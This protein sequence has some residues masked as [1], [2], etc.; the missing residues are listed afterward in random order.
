MTL[1]AFTVVAVSGRVVPA[2]SDLPDMPRATLTI[3]AGQAASAIPRS[4]LGLSTEYWSLPLYANHLRLFERVVSMLHVPGDGPL[5]LR[6]G[7]DSSDRVFWDPGSQVLPPWSYSITPAWTRLVGGIARR[8]RVRLILDLNLLTGSPATAAALARAAEASL[9]RRSIIGFEIGNESDIYNRSVWAK[10]THDRMAADAV[11]RATMSRANYV[12]DFRLYAH[13]LRAV[14]PRV[15]LLGPSLAQPQKHE[16]WA[17]AL[18]ASHQR[19]LSVITAHR[20]SFSGCVHRRSPRYPT[21]ARMLSPAAASGLSTSVA[22]DVSAA[23][24]AGLRFRLDELNSVNCGGRRGVSNSFATALWAPSA[25]F[26]LLLAGVDGVN[27]HIRADMINAPFA[28]G[29]AGLYARPLLYGLLTFT[30]ALGSRPRLVALHLR[31]RRSLGLRAWAVRS[32]RHAL[33]VLLVDEGRRSV[34]VLL[35][36]PTRGTLRIQRLLAPSVMSQTG[37]TFD[38]QWLGRD[39]RWQGRP[40]RDTAAKARNGY[41]VNVPRFSAALL[42]AR[43]V[44]GALSR[45][46]PRST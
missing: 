15:P 44:R 9:P 30:G 38:G 7:G 31:A 2:D 34:R 1:L 45:A 13:A 26:D 20:Y 46:V 24:R 4:Y 21:I 28:L 40:A 12:A 36:L 29:R 10:F 42:S 5:V 25:L 33:H 18:I 43:L 11:L 6:I 3:G 8:L 16:T 32:G 39:G 17:A 14:A 19:G 22:G 23:H 27:I 35:R 37:T 41:V